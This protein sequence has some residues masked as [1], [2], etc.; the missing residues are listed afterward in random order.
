MRGEVPQERDALAD[1]MNVLSSHKVCQKFP[2]ECSDHVR[3]VFLE[4]LQSEVSHL[5]L[6]AVEVLGTDLGCGSFVHAV[7]NNVAGLLAF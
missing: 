3:V 2:G 4:V 1:A 6:F 7:C 5:Q